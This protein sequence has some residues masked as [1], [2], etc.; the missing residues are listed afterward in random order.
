MK[1]ESG[2]RFALMKQS[3]CQESVLSQLVVN[4]IVVRVAK[5]ARGEFPPLGVRCSGTS[6][7]GTSPLEQKFVT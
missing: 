4:E 6:G 1:F 7:E 5:E 2:L 3:V